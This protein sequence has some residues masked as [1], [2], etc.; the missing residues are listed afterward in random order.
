MN[1]EPVALQDGSA[2]TLGV[3]DDIW[4]TY[5]ISAKIAQAHEHTKL[6]T[7]R[8]FGT[9]RTNC[10]L[11]NWCRVYDYYRQDEFTGSGDDKARTSAIGQD[12]GVVIAGSLSDDFQVIKLDANGTLEWRFQVSLG[13]YS[14][15]LTPP[16]QHFF[17][18]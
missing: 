5:R 14:H 9:C 3:S 16:S 13:Y 1:S 18:L 2:Q 15:Q 7:H 11:P 10:R 12:G 6:H 17:R 8:G 4:S